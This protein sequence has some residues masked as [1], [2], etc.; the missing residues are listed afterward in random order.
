MSGGSVLRTDATPE[1][2]LGS[3]SEKLGYDIFSQFQEPGMNP[4]EGLSSLT[5]A[6]ADAGEVVVEKDQPGQPQRGKVFAAVHAHVADVAR[7]AGGLCAKLIREGY[8][9]YLVR[10]TNDE[11]SG[12]QSTAQN[13]LSNEQEHLKVA[14]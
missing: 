8:T 5:T 4:T 13:I 3:K 6:R 10:T 12:G 7:Y 14:A 2:Q 9:G 11:K 1:L